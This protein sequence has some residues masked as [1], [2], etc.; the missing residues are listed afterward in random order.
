M[1]WEFQKGLR[2]GEKVFISVNL[3]SKDREGTVRASWRAEYAVFNIFA[4]EYLTFL[5]TGLVNILG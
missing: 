3:V 5:E 1:W 4:Y 2:W